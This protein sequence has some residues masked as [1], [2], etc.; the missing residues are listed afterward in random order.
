MQLIKNREKLGNI[1]FV[2]AIVIEV[3]IMMTDHMS[4]FT[5]PFRGRFAQ[6]AFVLFGCKI[7]TTR[8]TKKQWLVIIIL[9]MLGT[10]S[11][12]T[13]GDEYVLRAAVMIIASKD[14]KREISY[15]I[16]FIGALVG[17]IIIIGMAALGLNGRLY[18]IKDYGRD[19]IEKRWCLGFNHANNIHCMFWYI[20]A[21]FICA[22]KS[23]R[24]IYHYIILLVADVLLYL[25]TASKTGLIATAILVV[26]T[27]FSH[28]FKKLNAA[29]LPY[30]L[31]AFAVTAC[32]VVS[33]IGARYSC[34]E[35]SFCAKLDGFLNQRLNM[36]HDYANLLDWRLFPGPR[37]LGKAV[38]NGIASFGYLYG[39]VMLV[40]MLGSIYWIILKAY[41]EK[42]IILM[43]LAV[44]CTFVWFMEST[45]IINA[46]LLCTLSYILL[47]DRW[48]ISESV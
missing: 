5:L 11:Y 29:K 9:G 25:L 40:L 34:F 35:S 42:S 16:I 41:K 12:F 15:N 39:I 10:V 4:S 48:Y 21:L 2:A 36:S 44:T 28:Y 20:T 22:R 33:I 43:T 23:I 6:L 14:V 17:T 24:G 26:M 31:G 3:A 32:T 19:G 7:L 18:E 45:F 47:F 37:E 8:Y 30:I 1:L 13:M 46:S 38:D 27:A